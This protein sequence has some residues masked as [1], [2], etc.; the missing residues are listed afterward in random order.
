MPGVTAADAFDAE[1]ATLDGTMFLYCLHRI[2]RATRK[3]AAA[4]PQKGADRILID[5][6]QSDQQAFHH[7]SCFGRSRG[8]LSS[9][10]TNSLASKPASSGSGLAASRTIRS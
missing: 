10:A 2:F 4:S 1:P 7:S 8:S 5:P 9:S 6:K 3:V